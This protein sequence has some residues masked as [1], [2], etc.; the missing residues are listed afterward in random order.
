MASLVFFFFCLWRPGAPSAART[1]VTL[2]KTRGAE[3]AVRATVAEKIIQKFEI[4]MA[5]EVINGRWCCQPYY[6]VTRLPRDFHAGNDASCVHAPPAIRRPPTHKL[7]RGFSLSGHRRSAAQ[8]FLFAR[9]IGVLVHRDNRSTTHAK[10]TLG[11][12]L[13]RNTSS[14]VLFVLAGHLRRKNTHFFYE[15][16]VLTLKHILFNF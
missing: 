16:S 9:K 6:T 12:N 4:E 14:H 13:L 2:S 8:C 1:A 15:N 3:T 5:R 7:C 11:R 10:L